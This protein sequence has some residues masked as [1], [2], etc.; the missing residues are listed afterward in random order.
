[1][2][3]ALSKEQR[4]TANRKEMQLWGVIQTKDS[5]QHLSWIIKPELFSRIILEGSHPEG[6]TDSWNNGTCGKLCEQVMQNYVQSFHKSMK[7][8]KDFRRSAPTAV[9]NAPWSFCAS[10]NCNCAECRQ[11]AGAS[12][13]QGA[14]IHTAKFASVNTKGVGKANISLNKAERTVWS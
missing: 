2:R 14:E 8:M 1:M 4:A 9:I 13:C 10:C 3:F 12:G 5:I 6:K 11:A 7:I